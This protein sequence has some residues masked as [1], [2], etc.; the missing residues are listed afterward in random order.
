M[1]LWLL[2][3]MSPHA[4]GGEPSPPLYRVTARAP[5]ITVATPE[6]AASDPGDGAADSAEDGSWFLLIDRQISVTAAGDDDYEHLAVKALTTQ[7]VEN[8]AQI[9]L[10]V[11]PTYQTLDIHSIRVVRSGRA[12]EQ[13][14]TARMTAL[15]EETELQNRVYNGRY[16][17][18]V[19]LSDVRVGDVIEYDYTLHSREKIF[20]G[21]YAARWSVAWSNPV[22][23]QR[24]RILSPLDRQMRYQLSSAVP[25]PAPKIRGAVREF[26][27]EWKDLPAI[28]ADDD[29]PRW[30]TTWPYLEVS[31]LGDWSAVA[32]RVSP[33]FPE[34]PPDSPALAAALAEIRAGGGTDE[35]RALRALQYVQ[36]QIRYVSIAIGPGA[37]RPADP[38]TVLQ[39][40]F[41][42]CKDKSLLLASMLRRLGIDAQPALVHSRRGKVL[43][44][45]L[46]TPFAFNHAIVRAR[47]GRNDYW[48][49]PT[50]DKRYSPLATDSPADF[51][52]A[53]IVDRA[54]TEL[55][56]IP[57][58]SPGVRR[59]FSAVVID[60]SGGIDKP[61]RLDITT[62]YMGQ[63]A[64]EVR[65]TLTR[66]S[67]EQRQAD[68]A[69]YIARYYPGAKTA[70]PIVI[71]DDKV[72][73]I[74]EVREHYTLGRTFEQ[75]PKGDLA[76]SFHGDEIYR[77]TD[78]L[79]SSVRQ[80][81]LSIEYPIQVR[82][83]IKA[84]LPDTWPVQ[85]DAVTIENP[86]FKY[87]S[88]VS[89]SERGP[90]PQAEFDYEYEA[91]S[92]QVDVAALEKYQ[93]DRKRAYDDVGYTLRHAQGASTTARL[94]ISPLP[95]AVLLLS[96]A[97]GTW[98]AVRWGY[99]YD[100]PAAVA[101]GDAPAGI[102]GWLLIPAF[103][104]VVS[105]FVSAWAFTEWGHFIDADAWYTLPSIVSAPYRAWAQ[106]MLLAAVG[107]TGLL[108]VAHILAA[109]LFF[110]KRTSAPAAF[111]AV[112][113][114]SVAYSTAVLASVN[115]SGLDP[116]STTEH[117]AEEAI[118]SCISVVLWTVYML[119]S[120]RVKATFNTRLDRIPRMT[121]STNLSE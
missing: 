78:T 42:D 58:P 105:P 9:N 83:H 79:D 112:N 43:P 25:L 2:S 33:L 6:Y 101:D 31:D 63:F 39:R 23:W 26:E 19:L 87:G 44:R 15:P 38:D 115:L 117:T 8:Q 107:L 53:L 94:A 72:K 28:V 114:F 29:R 51:E 121:E 68:Y 40:R 76:F 27:V 37:Y 96:L 24:I 98:A 88:K 30:Y 99:R 75:T 49:D 85:P 32:A 80:A 48:L 74:V 100:P 62:S 116:H 35:Q 64:D 21:H 56:A 66:H 50:E 14:A 36:E 82:Q 108:L 102:R 97:L 11:D 104:T 77:Y 71:Q 109:I 16:N 103:A 65:R 22:H 67:P 10:S 113:W 5:W 7:G 41:G 3:G 93:A 111:I 120:R 91:L 110:K 89:Y 95:L 54:T 119:K 118:R 17:V 46:P 90:H 60:M 73:N 70:A 86:A 47:I 52:Q 1:G 61:A 12:I 13:S 81:P 57:R 18:N 59:K 45:A 20:P 106:P 69:N 55:T 84:I 92:D 4:W 34:D